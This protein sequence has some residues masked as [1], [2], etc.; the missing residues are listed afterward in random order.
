MKKGWQSVQKVVDN[1]FCIVYIIFIPRQKMKGVKV[2]L[3]DLVKAKGRPTKCPPEEE[4]AA[5]Y[6]CHTAKEVA[7]HYGVSVNTVKSW[8]H[9]YRQQGV[10][11]DD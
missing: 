6:S 8:I 4:L 9:R 2:M 7:K 5:L 10:I 1:G 11:K 3:K